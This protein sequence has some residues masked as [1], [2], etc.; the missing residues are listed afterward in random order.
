MRFKLEAPHELPGSIYVESGTIIGDDSPY[1]MDMWGVDVNG[2]SK[3]VPSSAMIPLDDE[4]LALWKETAKGKDNWGRPVDAIPITPPV[5]QNRPQQPII[6]APIEHITHPNTLM[7]DQR[8]GDVTTLLD[9]EAARVANEKRAEEN[10]RRMAEES[11]MRE[12]ML[13]AQKANPPPKT[14]GQPPKS[15]PT[16]QARVPEPNKNLHPKDGGGPDLNLK[17]DSETAKAP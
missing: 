12:K 8:P 5:T 16:S 3:F 11:N 17:K 15:P 6:P 9:P 1:P 7:P 2:K 10:D 13:A 4:A 14:E